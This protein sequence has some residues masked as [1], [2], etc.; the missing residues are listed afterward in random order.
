MLNALSAD[1][2][3]LRELAVG[4]RLS[5]QRLRRSVNA[6][7]SV[8][9]A[10]EQRARVRIGSRLGTGV[11]LIGHALVRAEE[12]RAR[13]EPAV[14]LVRRYAETQYCRRRLILQLLGEERLD[15]CENCAAGRVAPLEEGPF[16]IGQGVDHS[17]WGRGTVQQFE[18]GRVVVLFDHA[19]YRTL[20]LD[21][22]EETTCCDRPVS[23]VRPRERRRHPA[24][25]SPAASRP[26]PGR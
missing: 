15:A 25:S 8:G 20:S 19:G 4:T 9:A 1:P 21:L 22:V 6:L 23:R 14:E 11:E 24:A 10:Y 5:D 26:D 17:E 16:A 7:V 18:P 2:V 12:R 13:A 3:H